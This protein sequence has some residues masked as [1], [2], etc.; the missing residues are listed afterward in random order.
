MKRLTKWLGLYFN[1]SRSESNGFVILMLLM[2]IITVT[3]F[4]YGA[5]SSQRP[6]ALDESLL[7]SLLISIEKNAQIDSIDVQPQF[8]KKFKYQDYPGKRKRTHQFEPLPKYEPKSIAKFDI[9]AADTL[10][11]KQLKGIGTVLSKRIVKYRNILGGFVTLD[12]L[13]EVYGLKDSVLLQLDSMAFISPEFQPKKI[14]INT[15]IL[16][17]LSRHP[18]IRRPLARAINNYRFQHGDYSSTVDLSNIRLLDSL[19]LI[20]ITPY[21]SF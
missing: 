8:Y 10:Q 18:Y 17:S 14:N 19:T 2:L 16:D 20:K 3:V 11:L 12:Q 9:N 15:A 6:L 5:G 7:D 21:I 1:I 13:S 4:W